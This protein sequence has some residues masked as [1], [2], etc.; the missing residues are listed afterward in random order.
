[1][2]EA[3]GPT[4]VYVTRRKTNATSILH[5]ESTHGFRDK[6]ENKSSKVSPWH[7]P[8]PTKIVNEEEINER[9]KNLESKVKI[10]QC[11]GK[12]PKENETI[13]KIL[14]Q[15]IC[16]SISGLILNYHPKEINPRCKVIQECLVV[17]LD[18]IYPRNAH[19]DETSMNMYSNQQYLLTIPMS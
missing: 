3:L 15:M 10:K 19:F 2:S 17:P 14:P 18:D 4:H 6:V 8:M 9:E 16:L 5:E 11:K 12:L 13:I 1:M 7:E